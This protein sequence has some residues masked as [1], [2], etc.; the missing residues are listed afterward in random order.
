MA[1]KKFSKLAFIVFIPIVLGVGLMIAGN[2]FRNDA[3]SKAGSM[4]LSIGIPLTMVVLVGVGLVMIFRDGRS[5]NVTPLPD[6]TA[7]NGGETLQNGAAQSPDEI[8]KEKIADINSSYGYESQRKYNKYRMDHSAEAYR[9]SDK[10]SRVKGLVLM[11][12]LLTCFALII[13]FS[14][15]KLYIGAIVCG[16]LFAG[17]IIIFIIVA[18]ITE[19]RAMRS[20]VNL[21]KY[22]CKTG[23]VRGCTI[24]SS[25]S[26]DGDVTR[27]TVRVTSVTYR[28]VVTVDGKD[29]N[30]Y[31]KRYY[32]AGEKLAVYVRKDGKGIAVIAPQTPEE[33]AEERKALEEELAVRKE[34][35]EEL[36]RG[37]AQFHSDGK[38]D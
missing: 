30:T 25:S 17:T 26:T 5:S 18:K 36:E 20:N 1:M 38:K 2:Y 27:S 9:L 4:V 33:E 37:Q 15:F 22:D 7:A 19:R 32:G 16:G 12:F 10:K 28:V 29:Y 34:H 6:D 23:C 21:D 31:S 14:F 8:E 35:I 11:V 3:V 13:V 24:S